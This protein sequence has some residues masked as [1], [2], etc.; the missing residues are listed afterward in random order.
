MK[1]PE[2]LAAVAGCLPDPSMECHPLLLLE[3]SVRDSYFVIQGGVPQ[4]H[5]A[6]W[7]ESRALQLARPQ[8]GADS[9]ELGD[10]D[11][12]ASTVGL[13]TRDLERGNW[14]EMC[15]RASLPC[16]A[17]P[18]PGYHPQGQDFPAL[19]HPHGD[20]AQGRAHFPDRETESQVLSSQCW[21]G[22]RAEA[23]LL[24]TEAH[25]AEPAPGVLSAGR[26]HGL[27]A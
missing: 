27:C 13:C 26:A 6:A 19:G 3:A 25:S 16:G 10:P 14:D 17:A 1:P 7:M 18:A 9:L 5:V 20:P 2:L 8:G 21:I 15:T 24:S 4:G 11:V 12:K 23:I 22:F